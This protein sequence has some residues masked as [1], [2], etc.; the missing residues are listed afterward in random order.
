MKIKSEFQQVISVI[1]HLDYKDKILLQTSVVVFLNGII[2]IGKLILGALYFSD[3]LIMNAIYYLML[4]G[5]KENALLSYKEISRID[6]ANKASFMERKYLYRSGI[7]QCLIGV[8]Y[9]F[10]SLHSVYKPETTS[11]PGYLV[12]IVILISLEKI[13]CAIWGIYKTRYMKSLVLLVIKIIDFT[14]ALVSI[15]VTRGIV[16]QIAYK[17]FGIESGGVLGICCSV[18]FIGIGLF[19]IFI[20]IKDERKYER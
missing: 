16:Q 8:S 14:D 19:M 17:E 9:F 1:M 13:G 4:A 12:F 11:Y 20:S 5:G 2:G 18:L 3:W 7:F 15:V 10:V 6:D